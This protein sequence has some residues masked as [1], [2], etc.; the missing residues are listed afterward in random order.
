[1]N[2]FRIGAFPSLSWVWLVL[3]WAASGHACDAC[4]GGGVYNGFGFMPLA[5]RPVAGLSLRHVAFSHPEGNWN[6]DSRVLADRFVSANLSLRWMPMERVRLTA[7]VPVQ[8]HVREESLRTT[9][10]TGVGDVQLG[11]DCNVL[12]AGGPVWLRVGGGVSAPTG[13][14]MARDEALRQLPAAFQLGRGAW[15]ARAQV[16]GVVVR[17]N[18]TGSV[19]AESGRFLAN[20]QGYQTGSQSRLSALSYFRVA[21]GERSW[22]PYAGGRLERWGNDLDRG[23]TVDTGGQRW[24]AIAGLTAQWGDQLV[25]FTWEHPIAQSLKAATPELTGTLEV[26]WAWQWAPRSN[27]VQYN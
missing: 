19:A 11:A 16:S 1:M 2:F 3:G 6:G 9:V 12:A 25:T 13:T 14:Y 4:G 18:W 10:L 8:H 21:R 26:S 15:G 23:Q 22:L 20:E 5:Q 27:A 17:G 24:T 7:T